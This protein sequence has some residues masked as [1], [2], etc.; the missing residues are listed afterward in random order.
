MTSRAAPGTRRTRRSSRCSPRRRSSGVPVRP[1]PRSSS[2]QRSRRST[3]TRAARSP[4]CGP[5]HRRHPGIAAP[6][7]V[8]A[9]GTW[10]AEV[11]ALAGAID[12]GA[13]PSWLHPR[14]RAVA[15][16]RPAQGLHG[17]LRRERRLV[18]RGPPD[19]GRHR[20]HTRRDG[21]HR[22]EPRAG[23]LRRA[24]SACPSSGG[25]RRRRS[26]CSRSSGTSRCSGRTSGSGRTARTTCRSSARTRACRDSSM[27]AATRE[28][29]SGLPPRPR[30]CSRS[31]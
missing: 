4:G 18:G 14:D 22:R 3:A 15:A 6:C 29:A 21:A 19:V 16:R 13:A 20:G 24:P 7:V 25:S 9:A 27:P 8:N 1:A 11:A 28:R 10:A 30:S 2:G 5:T 17:R 31:T 12:P 23:R 26:G